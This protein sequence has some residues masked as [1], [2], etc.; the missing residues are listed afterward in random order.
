M[1][2]VLAR[3]RDARG[4]YKTW[5]APRS[6]YR[7]IDPGANP[8]PTDLAIQLNVY[9]MLRELAP[10]SAQALCTSLQR[11]FADGDVWVYYARA[12]LLPY[13]RVAELTQLGCPL[14]FPTDRLALPISDQGIWS[15]AA[16]LLVEAHASV[17]NE[18][19]REKMNVL[20]GHVGAD[21]FALLKRAP[22]LIYHNDL[23]ANVR[24]YY[25]SEDV[26]Y[27][28]WLRLYDAAGPDAEPESLRTP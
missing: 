4:L 1:L 9:L 12:P 7:C 8:N 18:E 13:L 20:L 3:Y 27:A 22:P 15:E 17:P 28:L 25:W 11:A 24:R 14:P 10:P 19:A 2:D 5:L 23:T 16:Y 26:G 21:D 6:E